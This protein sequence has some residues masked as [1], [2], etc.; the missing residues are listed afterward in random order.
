[1]IRFLHFSSQP[2]NW[3]SFDDHLW[4]ACF[5][6][7]FLLLLFAPFFSIEYSF[8][9]YSLKII[10]F[11]ILDFTLLKI[12]NTFLQNRQLNRTDRFSPTFMTSR[13]SSTR[14]GERCDHIFWLIE[15]WLVT[16]KEKEKKKRSRKNVLPLLFWLFLTSPSILRHLF[17]LFPSQESLFDSSIS[18][19]LPSTSFPSF[20]IY[21]HSLPLILH[22]NCFP[23]TYLLSRFYRSCFLDTIFFF[24][25]NRIENL[26]SK[27][28]IWK[29]SSSIFS[30]SISVREERERERVC[31]QKKEKRK[32]YKVKGE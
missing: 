12:W 23:L 24:F 31:G 11:A 27:F 19:S 32:L 28:L 3:C 7:H 10:H 8:L 25:K 13:R 9:F 16:L 14:S 15:V 22:W 1:M 4:E 20:F 2:T 21:F 17:F 30:R 26:R 18:S 6:S 29:S 5:S